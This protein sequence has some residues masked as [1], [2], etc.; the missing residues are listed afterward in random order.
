MHILFHLLFHYSLSQ[1]TEY[2]SVCSAV[3]L[4][5]YA[6]SVHEFASA[7]PGPPLCRLSSPWQPQVCSPSL[8]QFHRRVYLGCILDSASVTSYD[9]CL[10]L[11]SLSTVISGPIRGA[12]KGIVP[13]FIAAQCPAVSVLSIFFGHS[14]AEGHA[15]CFHVL[16]VGYSAAMNTR[17][18]ISFQIRVCAP[19]WRPRKRTRL[20]MHKTW[21]VMVWPL[22][23]EDF[24][25]ERMATH[26][27][28]LPG[29]SVD[30][31]AWWAAVHGVTQSQ[32]HE[33]T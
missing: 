24:L 11:T 5:V 21:E 8:F 3:E 26:S 7:H 30:R 22:G 33:A 18:H 2:S 10:W 13:S 4:I 31:G 15:G 12:V 6:F 9:I 27:S 20:P 14:P 25:E 1:D 17:A 32:T 16:A 29:E 28:V 19:R 23:W